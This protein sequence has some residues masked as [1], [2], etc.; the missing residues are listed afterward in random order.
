[1]KVFSTALS[2]VSFPHRRSSQRDEKHPAQGCEE[3]ATLGHRP[4]QFINS[5]RVASIP[6]IPFVEFH[7]VA[8][9]KFPK[10]ILKRNLAVMFDSTLSGLGKLVLT[11]TQRSRYASTLGWMIAILSGLPARQ[12]REMILCLE[13]KSTN[14]CDAILTD[15]IFW[16]LDKCRQA[17]RGYG[18]PF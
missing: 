12:A 3:R 4:N 18:F 7:R 14:Y 16:L 5:E 10:L 9:Q 6:H 2:A 1:M 17:G 8:F 15:E 11:L 13:V